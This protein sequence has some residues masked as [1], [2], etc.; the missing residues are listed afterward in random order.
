[1]LKTLD[2][3]ATYEIAKRSHNWL[4][5]KKDYVSNI[6]DT[7]D[8]VVIGGYLGAGKRAG[9]YGAY[10][11]ACYDPENQQYQSI[12]KVCSTPPG[13]GG[14]PH[15]GGC[16]WIQIGTGLKDE[17]L[18]RQYKEFSKLRIDKV[19][20]LAVPSRTASLYA[21]CCF[22]PP[23]YYT[24]DASL[25]PD[26]WFDTAVVWE[27]KAADLSISPRHRAAIGL[28]DPNKGE[29]RFHS[30]PAP[31]W[32]GSSRLHGLGI[33]LRFPRYIRDRP[34]KKPENATTAEQVASL[35][36]AQMEERKEEFKGEED[37]EETPDK[38]GDD[39]EDNGDGEKKNDDGGGDEDE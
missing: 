38:N 30:S 17:D 25:K 23:A 9:G 10:L 7:V 37:D 11:L 34:D 12:C 4:K 1:M 14:R 32:I 13:V 35:Y 22:Q 31:I 20:V 39:D 29:C 3:N 15:V 24:V 26:H 6:G 2:E 21:H 5:L 27:V 16:L 8:L 36:K 18:T 33:S 28:V 19:G